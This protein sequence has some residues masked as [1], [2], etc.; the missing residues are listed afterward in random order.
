MIIIPFQFTLSSENDT[1]K[2]NYSF[3]FGSDIVSRYVWRGI[4]L[5]ESPCIQ[6]D[7][8]FSYKHLVIGS[9]ASYSFAKEPLQEVDMYLK[10]ETKFFSLSVCDYY[11][12]VDSL[13]FQD[14]FLNWKKK[15]TRHS[16]EAILEIHG[17]EGFPLEI[18]AGTM[19]FGNDRDVKM[20]N[21]YSTYLEMKYSTRMNTIDFEPFIGMTFMDGLY[22]KAG[23]MNLGFRA[24]KTISLSEKF[25]LPVNISFGLNPQVQRVYFVLACSF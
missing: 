3:D 19:F 6:P 4:N 10:Y 1:L 2:P 21:N 8:E 24:S 14:D 11:N 17:P 22:G 18:E 15:T 23:L 13:G 20:N 7:F 16:L 5:S 9:W 25:E 12:P